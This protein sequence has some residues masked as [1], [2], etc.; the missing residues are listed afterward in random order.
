MTGMTLRKD[1]IAALARQTAINANQI[2]RENTEGFVRPYVTR[3]RTLRELLDKLRDDG[4]NY[5]NFVSYVFDP[6]VSV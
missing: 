4:L 1:V 6:K 3:S 5:S 2:I